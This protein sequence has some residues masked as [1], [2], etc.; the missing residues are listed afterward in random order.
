MN[1]ARIPEVYEALILAEKP[2]TKKEAC[3]RLGISYNT[4]RLDKLMQEYAERKERDKK[5]RA[6][7]RGKP[8][9]EFEIQ[10]ILEGYL[11]K[12]TISELATSLYRSPVFVKNVLT[13]CGIPIRSSDIDFFNPLF[14]DEGIA[15]E[16]YIKGEIAY[17]ARHL[18]TV[19]IGAVA[20][21][22]L[23]TCYWCYLVEGQYKVPIMW[24]DLIPLQ[25]LIDK[26]KLKIRIDSGLDCRAI[27][28]ETL[29][30]V[31]KNAKR[32]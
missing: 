7:N 3:A 9:T 12:A 21:S 24:W 10:S 15:K 19:E 16:E 18:D 22:D 27:I 8:A 20:K 23:G 6:K 5:M 1:E 4:A 29:S 30:K 25:H 26:Y 14:I 31:F 28:A 11:R 17:S 13:K 32:D 2:I